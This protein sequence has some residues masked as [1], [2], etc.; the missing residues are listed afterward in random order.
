MKLISHRGNINGKNSSNENS[1]EAIECCLIK[2]LDIEVDLWFKDGNFYLGH[3]LPLF[4]IN[5]N[6]INNEK[7]WFHIKNIETF[8]VIKKYD[9]KNYFWHQDDLCTLTSSQKFWLYPGNFISSKDSIFVL[10]DLFKN[11]DIHRYDYYAICT[12]EISY[13]KKLLNL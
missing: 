10:P 6:E 7:F 8:S 5:I 4:K 11:V 13:F 12:D 1:L 9:I 3:D 2:E